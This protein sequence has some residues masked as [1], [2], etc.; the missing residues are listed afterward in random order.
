[1]A[2]SPPDRANVRLV[3]AALFLAI[4]VGAFVVFGHH[5]AT[6]PHGFAA[7]AV[8]VLGLALA[9][10]V[11]A[12]WVGRPGDVLRQWRIVLLA[13]CVGTL[14]WDALLAWVTPRHIFFDG[15]L[16]IYGSSLV[17]FG[18]LLTLHGILVALV[19]GVRRARGRR[20]G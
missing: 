5:L 20:I 16:L 15:G 8:N 11:P 1:V 9:F 14:A 17:F 4:A 18:L 2:P 13:V 19:G 6:T 7:Y 10:L 3:S 12:Q